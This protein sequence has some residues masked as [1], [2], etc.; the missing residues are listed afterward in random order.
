MKSSERRVGATVRVR[1]L[2]GMRN[3][4]VKAARVV[5]RE[6][7]EMGQQREMVQRSQSFEIE[8]AG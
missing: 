4:V 7:G 8:E 5:S 1:M 6:E 3:W 2:G